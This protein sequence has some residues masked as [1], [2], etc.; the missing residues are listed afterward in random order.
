MKRKRFNNI[1]ADRHLGTCLA[2]TFRIDLPRVSAACWPSQNFCV[3]LTNSIVDS[4]HTAENTDKKADRS[5]GRCQGCTINPV[6]Q[7]RIF[8]K[9]GHATRRSMSASKADLKQGAKQRV[10]TKKRSKQNDTQQCGD[11][12]LHKTI[13]P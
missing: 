5:Y 13:R 11:A 1:L 10:N 7:L 8:E 6:K 4:P 9:R 3:S 2:I 12:H